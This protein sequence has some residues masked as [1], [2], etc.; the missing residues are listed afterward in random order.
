MATLVSPG[1]SVQI[2]DESFFIP[3]SAPTVP[4]FFITT[5]DEKL[6]PDGISPALGTFEFDVVRTVTSLTQSTQLYGVPNFLEDPSTGDPQHGDARNEYGLFALNQ[7]L[8]VGNRA[9]VIRTNVNLDDDIA[10]IRLQWNNKFNA[11]VVGAVVMLQNAIQNF[12]IEKV[13]Y[14]DERPSKSCRDDNKIKDIA[15]GELKSL[16]ALT[17]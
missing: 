3:V 12:L 10:S 6:Q 17:S 11:A 15:E 4:L 8:G 2:T 9:Y 16:L 7:Y 5:A 1:V 13:A 14:T